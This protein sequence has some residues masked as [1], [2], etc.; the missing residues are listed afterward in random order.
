MGLPE[1]PSSRIAEVVSESLEERFS[2]GVFANNITN[3]LAN[4]L[5]YIMLFGLAFLLI[6]II[7]AVIGNLI[8]IALVLP[9][10]RQLDAIG[11]AVLGL[12]KGLIIVFAIATV[13]RYLGL[14]ISE[15]LHETTIL[16]FFVNRNPIANMLGI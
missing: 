11:G 9:G 3:R 1:S 10:L 15:T 5:S 16:Y 12:V 13:L 2:V 7:F 6:S 8:G 4:T 14:F